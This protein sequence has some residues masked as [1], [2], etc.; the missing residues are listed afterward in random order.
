MAEWVLSG[1][2]REVEEVGSEGRP[3]GFGGE[4]GDVLVGVVELCDDLGSEE[5]FGCDVEAVGVALDSLEQP[6]RWVVELA[7][8]A[9]WRRRAIR[10]GRGSAAAS[11]S[12]CAVRRCRVGS[13]CGGRRRRRL[14]GRGGWRAG[15]G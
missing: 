6:G 2:G 11:R 1:F 7:Q 15:R 10:R 12:G 5:L 8:Q 3:G 4:A 13:G 9:C 14:G